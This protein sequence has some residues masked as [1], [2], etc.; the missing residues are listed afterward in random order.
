MC[1]KG[2]SENKPKAGRFQCK[3][4]GAVTKKKKNICKPEKIKD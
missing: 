2:K 1:L 4:C 3:K